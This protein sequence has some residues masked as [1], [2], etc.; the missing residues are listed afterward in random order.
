[1]SIS[2]SGNGTVTSDPP[3]IDCGATCAAV[4][5]EGTLVTLTPAPDADSAFTGWTGACT[6]TGPCHGGDERRPGGRGFVRR[7]AHPEDRQGRHRNRHRHEQ[8]SRHRLWPDLLGKLRARDRRDPD[9]HPGCRAA[10]SSDGQASAPGSRTCTLTMGADRL[11][12]ATFSGPPTE[13]RTLLVSKAGSGSGD[14]HEHSPGNRLRRDVLGELHHRHGRHPDRHA[15]RR[16]RLRRLVGRLFRDGDL[17]ADDERRSRGDGHVHRASVAEDADGFEGEAPA[18]A[19][20]R[21]LPPGIDCGPTCLASFAPG[22]AGH[23]HRHGRSGSTF[24]GWS[25]DCSGTGTCTVTMAADRAVTATFTAVPAP[26][27]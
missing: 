24:A 22:T 1:M 27:R 25:G 21:A 5:D 9:G 23:P 7:P 3:G 20:S 18:R 17:H 26:G 10:P 16:P 6:G 8:S 14:R 11:V 13:Q 2:G 15:R 12:T 4:F 19:R